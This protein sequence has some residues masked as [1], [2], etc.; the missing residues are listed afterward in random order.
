[1]YTY[2]VNTSIAYLFPVSSKEVSN[3]VIAQVL[4]MSNDP[5]KALHFKENPVEYCNN[6]NISEYARL[7]LS[8]AQE[9]KIFHHCYQ[10]SGDK[11]GPALSPEGSSNIIIAGFII[12]N[13][14]DPPSDD[15][16]E[17]C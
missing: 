3:E 8:A 16:I 15:D 12:N 11:L 2:T 17:A 4:A 5:W 13:L 1:M 7:E 14:S 10:I 9:G 6:L